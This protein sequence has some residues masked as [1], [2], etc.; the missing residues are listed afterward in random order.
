MG[1]GHRQTVDLELRLRPQSVSHTPRPWSQCKADPQT[2]H[3][4]HA[5]LSTD[6]D[7]KGPQAVAAWVHRREMFMLS[8]L[9]QFSVTHSRLSVMR[10]SPDTWPVG[11]RGGILKSCTTRA[12]WSVCSRVSSAIRN[13]VLSQILFGFFPT[14]TTT[15][16]K[17][18]RI[19]NRPSVARSPRVL[20]N[21]PLCGFSDSDSDSSNI[22]LILTHFACKCELLDKL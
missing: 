20:L 2:L 4:Y 17:G 10:H 19:G 21:P 1:L 15:Y 6:Y 12:T 11:P 22:T 3:S 8:H 9:R 16:L 13:R 14:S 5:G 18:G 7:E